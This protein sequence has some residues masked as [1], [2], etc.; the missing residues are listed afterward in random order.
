M[1]NQQC[2][3]MLRFSLLAAV[4]AA[5][6][7]DDDSTVGYSSNFWAMS[8]GVEDPFFTHRESNEQS[9]NQFCGFIRSNATMR[10]LLSLGG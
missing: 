1:Q 9:I 2:E 7:D 6:D 10:F 3:S 8:E 5:D 4:D